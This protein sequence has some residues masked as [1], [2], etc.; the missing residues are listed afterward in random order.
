MY[1]VYTASE[2][3]IPLV[4]AKEEK[5][6]IVQGL[7]Y[8]GK[9]GQVQKSKVFYVSVGTLTFNPPM[10]TNFFTVCRI[11]FV[12]AIPLMPTFDPEHKSNGSYI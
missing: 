4:L 2:L 7:Y 9:E 8:K 10:P 11:N 6:L 1:V 3:A 12:L 5:L